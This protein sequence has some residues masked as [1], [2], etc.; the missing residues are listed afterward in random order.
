[1]RRR[2]SDL[3]ALSRVAR[4]AAVVL[5]TVGAALA[6]VTGSAR[7][8][9]GAEGVFL[10]LPVGARAVGMGE[11][12]V[13]Q[14][15]GSDVLWWNPAGVAGRTEHEIAIHHS[16][17]IVGQ[18]NALA[19]VLPFHGVGTF[20]LAL[21]VLDLGRQAATD[22]QGNPQGVI[23][24]T[25]FE[26]GLTYAV[27][28]I[29]QLALGATV[30]HVEARIR[31]SGLCANLPVGGSNANGAD[32]GAQ[33]R[34]TGSPLTIGLAA[35]N[36]GVGSGSIRPARLDAGADYRVRVPK[37]YADLVDIH[38]AAGVVT[39]ARLDSATTRVGTDITLE[40]RLHVRAGYIHDATNGSGGAVGVGLSSGKL[41]FDL[42]RTFGGLSANG[43]KPPTY[44]SLRYLW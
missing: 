1:M 20:G 2:R 9:G 25:D 15:G 13:A 43:D 38:A 29:S 41:V 23:T 6:S 3:R 19:A 34:P 36:L 42:A 27:T 24:P 21:N 11:A 17:T 30:K 33:I 5:T 31:C 7:A 37:Q 28:P 10:L 39:T 8:Q 44:F 18:G 35:R 26:Y 16:E 12:V 22:D 14:Q 4:R 32:V 40:Q